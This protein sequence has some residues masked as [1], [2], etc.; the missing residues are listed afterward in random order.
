MIFVC[1]DHLSK[2]SLE[3]NC[4]HIKRVIF[5]QPDWKSS[6]AIKMIFYQV[7]NFSIPSTDNRSST[8]NPYYDNHTV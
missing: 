7:F 3:N 1:S 5:G 6:R 2:G 8:D 4:C